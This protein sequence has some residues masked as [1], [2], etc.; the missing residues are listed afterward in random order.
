M[1]SL[2]LLAK[3]QMDLPIMT[4]PRA[5][6]FPLMALSLGLCLLLS[7]SLSAQ[8]GST[9]TQE[10]L[11]EQRASTWPPERVY[12][13]VSL[14]YALQRVFRKHF[15]F[16]GFTAAAERRDY[17]PPDVARF[18]GKRSLRTKVETA[19]ISGGGLLFYIFHQNELSI[20][21]DVVS[22]SSTR[23]L[24]PAGA[25]PAFLLDP[26][27]HFDAFVFTKNCSGY[28]K[29]SLDAGIE[30]PYSA[31][32]TALT[33]DEKRESSVL[34]LSGAFVSPLKGVLDTRDARTTDLMLRL[35]HFY[36]QNPAYIGRA[37]YLREFEGV[38]VKHVGAAEDARRL[39]AEIGINVN[40]PL[41]SN[42]KANL[43]SGRITAGTF[44]GTD[45]ETIVFADYEGMYTRNDLF[46]P[47]PTPAEIQAYFA[48]LRPVFQ[49]PKDFPLM[50]EGAEH[51]H[52]LIVEGLPEEICRQPW[53][54]EE[55]R[56]GVYAGPLRWEAAYF[57]ES[58]GVSGGRFT[59]TGQPDPRLFSGSIAERPGQVRLSYTL[60]SLQPVGGA[61]LRLSVDEELPTSAHPIVSLNA[62]RFDLTLQED[63]RFAFQ[64]RCQLEVEDEDN[65]VDFNVL[66][67]VSNIRVW[68]GD[69]TAVETEVVNITP[70]PARHAFIITL[71]SRQ[72]WPLD[73]IDDKQMQ[74]YNL[75]MEVHLQSRRAPVR[76]VRQVRGF[77]AFPSLRPEAPVIIMPVEAPPA[78]GNGN[79][80]G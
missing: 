77:L 4:T 61:Y 19:D 50:T 10:R 9:R 71:E 24:N 57:K 17:I 5:T 37:Y 27:G 54:V 67:Y 73:R 47:L 26:N 76:T 8:R 62:G 51:K 72:T 2:F 43:G 3:Y 68:S 59:I 69:Q 39:D 7:T 53:V 30:P 22:Y 13:K 58:N 34:A 1:I 66:P 33:T 20:P 29:S 63:R 23:I 79:G 15:D 70:D 60:R 11:E 16:C 28:L 49:K 48:N 64:W 41:S 21:L 32:K 65:P 14:G 78:S 42:V 46:A 18:L 80:G 74:N 35:W 55:V 45:W 12:S 6:F 25:A 56:P 31:F 75:A 36:Q 44:S 40:G 52:Y 38:M